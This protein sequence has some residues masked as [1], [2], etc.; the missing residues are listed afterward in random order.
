VSAPVSPKSVTF[1]DEVHNGIADINAWG[2]A[3]TGKSG[4]GNDA[5]DQATADLL[6]ISAAT[7][8]FVYSGRARTVDVQKAASTSSMQKAIPTQATFSSP[9]SLRAITFRTAAC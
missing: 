5:L 6:S 9:K 3:E 2:G 1:I 8:P 4:A 7:E